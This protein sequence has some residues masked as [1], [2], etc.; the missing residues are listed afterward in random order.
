MAL[1]EVAELKTPAKSWVPAKKQLFING[2]WLDAKSGKTFDVENP[3]TG[4]VIA[5][6]A[7]GDKA[8]I[9][10]AV[11]AAR[12][13]FESGPWKDMSTSERGKI[14]WKIGDLILEN[15]DELANIIEERARLG[16]NRIA[17]S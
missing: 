12:K 9:D 17:V 7:E 16:F 14:I 8:D 1:A 3:A 6:V 2:K 10:A 5:K 4:D 11:K 13:A 15:A